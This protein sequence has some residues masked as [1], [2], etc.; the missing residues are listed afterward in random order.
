MKMC[1]PDSGTIAS[2]HEVQDA[3]A[4]KPGLLVVDDDPAV[5]SL[6][7]SGLPSYGFRV[8]IAESAAEALALYCRH[9]AAI[10]LVL[11]DSSLVDYDGSDLLAALRH[12]QP[13]IRCCFTASFLDQQGT[14][15]LFDQGAVG[16]LS[17]PFR[18][19]GLAAAL[20]LLTALPLRG[21]L[22]HT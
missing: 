19:D 3:T 14:E 17:K 20:R 12:L 15:R 18:L 21:R 10:H 4:N 5:G 1:F 16:I 7:A 8:W 22:G 9:S 6:L 13:G 11:L 2:A